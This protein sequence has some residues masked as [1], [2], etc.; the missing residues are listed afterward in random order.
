M[1]DVT[2]VKNSLDDTNSDDLLLEIINGCARDADRI[3][4]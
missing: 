3:P 1:S 4:V 2:A